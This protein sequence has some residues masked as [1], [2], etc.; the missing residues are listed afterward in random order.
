MMHVAE[1]TD[2]SNY[3]DE[4]IVCAQDGHSKDADDDEVMIVSQKPKNKGKEII[5]SDSSAGCQRFL[6]CLRLHAQRLYLQHLNPHQKRKR[7]L[8][9]VNMP[10]QVAPASI[11]LIT[12]DQ[13]SSSAININS[14]SVSGRAHVLQT[15]KKIKK[16]PLPLLLQED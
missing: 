13:S 15:T 4:M 3:E 12:Q 14:G 1:D 2:V 11:N 5:G 8:P 16:K 10:P 9:S 7:A 6:L